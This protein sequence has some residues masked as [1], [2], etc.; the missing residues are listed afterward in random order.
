MLWSVRSVSLAVVHRGHTTP[1][2][3]LSLH[4]VNLDQEKQEME[5][6]WWINSFPFL[7]DRLFQD[8]PVAYGFSRDITWLSDLPCFLVHL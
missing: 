8:V 5:N 3:Q 1:S 7:N 4:E 2:G 6:H